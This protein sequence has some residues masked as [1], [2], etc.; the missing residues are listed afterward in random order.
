MKMD[1]IETKKKI[2]TFCNFVV[3]LM[4]FVSG[5]GVRLVEVNQPKQSVIN[6]SDVFYEQFF[7]KK[8]VFW[9]TVTSTESSTMN[10]PNIAITSQGLCRVSYRTLDFKFGKN[11]VIE[12]LLPSG[13]K[14]PVWVDSGLSTWPIVLN[15]LI[16][17][18]NSLNIL[19]SGNSF[20]SGICYLPSLRINSLV[21]DDLT[22]LYVPK[23]WEF[24]F[25][26]FPVWQDRRII[27][28]LEAMSRFSYIR[29]DNTQKEIAFS[30]NQSFFPED[31]EEWN[32]YPFSL[33]NLGYIY[34]RRL[35]VQIPIDGQTHHLEF[36]TGGLDL[37]VNK[38]LWNTLSEKTKI[39][40]M[41][42]ASFL[43]HQYGLLPCQKVVIDQLDIGGVKIQNAG[44]D[45]LPD[46][47]PYL[48]D[49]RYGQLGMAYFQNTSLVLD[50]E[51]QMMWVKTS[52]KQTSHYI[53]MDK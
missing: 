28:G 38:E 48:L 12:G 4:L 35:I 11:I 6:N 41:Q 46:N 1:K 52:E 22:C 21:L 2:V 16:A 51:R 10:T 25:L 44:V 18:E 43:S 3:L 39:V 24:Q 36:D 30:H 42:P 47:S 5:C 27:L 29:F 49:G 15:D 7:N 53:V 17:S 9:D 20:D 40:N 13:E 32:H 33:E 31:Q 19:H 34:G 26:G 45:V 50:F 8:D 23:H 14:Y 37:A